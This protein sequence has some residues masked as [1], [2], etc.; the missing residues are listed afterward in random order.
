LFMSP[1]AA[2]SVTVRSREPDVPSN[3]PLVVALYQ[4]YD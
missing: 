3:L 4:E 1:I 2:N